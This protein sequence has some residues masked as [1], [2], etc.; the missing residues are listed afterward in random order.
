M[1][2]ITH[3]L[4]TLSSDGTLKVLAVGPALTSSQGIDI[5]WPCDTAASPCV[6][7][8]EGLPNRLK[9]KE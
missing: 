1:Q 8:L 7:E 4:L 9:L 2:P 6:V 3:D 5:Q